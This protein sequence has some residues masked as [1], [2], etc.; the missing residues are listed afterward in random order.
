MHGDRRRRLPA[1]A[2]AMKEDDERNPV[3]GFKSRNAASR[4]IHKG[5]TIQSL[6]CSASSFVMKSARRRPI[7][8]RQ[9]LQTVPGAHCELNV[10]GVQHES[11]YCRALAVDGRRSVAQGQI[12]TP[13]QTATPGHAPGPGGLRRRGLSERRFHRRSRFS[14]RHCRDASRCLRRPCEL[15]G[16][17]GCR[18]CLRTHCRTFGRHSTAAPRCDCPPRRDGAVHRSSRRPTLDRLP[19]DARRRIDRRRNWRCLEA[20]GDPR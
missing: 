7:S 16:V 5:I 6:R 11:R 12:A 17:V 13:V 15:G 2:P 18:R 20:S 3:R 14:K 1:S 8:Y 19:M 9:L 10:E 4:R